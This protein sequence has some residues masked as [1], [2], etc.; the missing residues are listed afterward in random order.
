MNRRL[1]SVLAVFALAGGTA[2][3]AVS[4]ASAASV[5]NGDFERGDLAW[6]AQSRTVG[7]GGHWTAYDAEEAGRFSVP[8]PPDG[9]FAAV[10]YEEP[11]PDTTLLL[12]EVTLDPSV[13]Q[14]LSLILWY[15]SAAP[16]SVPIPDT[17]GQGLPAS[18]NQQLRVDVMKPEAA[19]R[20]LESGDIL[21]TL[22]ASRDG[23]PEE[24]AP[25][26]LSADLSAFAGQTVKIRVSAVAGDGQLNVGVD[27][28]KIAGGSLETPPVVPPATPEVPITTPAPSTPGSTPSTPTA[29][30]P[31]NVFASGTLSRDKKSG[32]A[33]L[34]VAVPDA[35]TLVASD[36]G[37]KVAVASR[38]HKG[39]AK[40]IYVRTATVVS[41]GAG[42]IAVPIRPTAA[43]RGVLHRKGSVPVRLTMTFT[44]I[45]GSAASQAYA[46]KL[47]RR[48]S[49]GPR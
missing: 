16:I 18:G 9:L 22:Y 31:S 33:V 37:R 3:L 29:A 36:A 24:M 1:L 12:Q 2:L 13:S 45:G 15:H 43:A 23:D 25:T 19:N 30:P 40:P 47:V 26:Q 20:S 11:T 6:W 42:T 32:S 39:G 8:P 5:K 28:V 4:A 44:P 14:E 41:D 46:T 49:P 34:T 10:S 35:G 7:G 38:R 21:A 17:L 27:D 48:I